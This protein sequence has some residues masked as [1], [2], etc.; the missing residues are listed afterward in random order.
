MRSAR[1]LLSV[2][3]AFA[4]TLMVGVDPPGGV[5]LPAGLAVTAQGTP[6]V[7][8]TGEDLCPW[9]EELPSGSD[10][11]TGGDN[12]SNA[13]GFV[14]GEAP[15][16]LHATERLEASWSAFPGGAMGAV[17][18]GCSVYLFDSSDIEDIWAWYADTYSQRSAPSPEE[19]PLPAGTPGEDAR[20]F[21]FPPRF[22]RESWTYAF[23]MHNVI[24]AVSLDMEHDAG[25]TVEDIAPLAGAV[26][27]RI[28]AAAAGEPLAVAPAPTPEPAFPTQAESDLLGHVPGSFR[29]SCGRSEFAVSERAIAALVCS[30]PVEDGSVT[31]TYQQFADTVGLNEVYQN[32]L[33]F[34]GVE[35]DSGPCRV[36]QAGEGT[37]SIGGQQVGRAGCS[38]PGSFF[39]LISW[40]DDRVLI[41]GFAESFDADRGAV[42]DWWQ[43]DSGP[44]ASP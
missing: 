14:F 37:Y 30:V 33:S 23:R 32:T 5:T 17:S 7:T 18:P 43:T 2:L 20:L 26:A 44:L 11:V 19:L 25:A 29:D 21:H 8:G 16:Q 36:D 6:L 39:L 15:A 1:L 4:A 40:T 10:A 31:V 35:P 13:R 24:A 22:D 34:M 28:E 3:L 38:E 41:H 27:R 42:F 9:G 12:T